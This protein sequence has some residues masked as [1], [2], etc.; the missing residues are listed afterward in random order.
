MRTRPSNTTAVALTATLLTACTPPSPP[1]GLHVC[2]HEQ[3]LAD[4]SHVIET[5][6]QAD[7]N[8]VLQ[9]QVIRAFA[10]PSN[11]ANT[12]CVSGVA[13]H[14]GTGTFDY[15]IQYTLR[16]APDG[17][18]AHPDPLSLAGVLTAIRNDHQDELSTFSVDNPV[19]TVASQTKHKQVVG[20]VKK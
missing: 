4:I 20:L 13:V 7:S 9:V 8:E 15:A 17:I 6:A 11:S 1:V 16:T 12:A 5:A 19:D 2:N 3:H 10:I 18:R 14:S